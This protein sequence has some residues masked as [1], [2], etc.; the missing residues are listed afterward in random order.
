M[1]HKGARIA[2]IQMGT[3]AFGP[4]QTYDFM[5]HHNMLKKR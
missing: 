2:P 4:K 3:N 5:I 1:V